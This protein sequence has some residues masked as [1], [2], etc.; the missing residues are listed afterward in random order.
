MRNW[1]RYVR[2]HLPPLPI[3]AERETEIVEELAQQLEAAY[4]A[5]LAHGVSDQE[6]RARALAEVPDWHGL[7]RTLTDIERKAAPSPVIGEPTGSIMADFF[8]DLRYALRMLRRAPGFATLAI[9]TLALG[10]G[11]TTIVYSLVDGILLKPLPIKDPDRVVL[12]R[13]INPAGTERGVA[14]P[15]YEDWRARATSFESLAAWVGGTATLTGLDR[16]RRINGRSVTWDLFRTLG[17]QPII[18]RDFTAD[19]DRPGVERVCLISY[20]FWQ[21]ELGGTADAIGRLLTLNDQR[22]TIVGVLPRDFTV[23]RQEDVFRPIGE[24]LTPG[25]FLLSRGNHSGL[26]AIGR[27]APGATVES[28]RTELATIAA[29]LE[30][31]HPETNSGNGATT[32]PLF[33]VLVSDARPMLRVLMGAV[34]AMLLIACVNLANLLLAR[35]SARSQELAVRW[36][37]PARASRG[38]CSPRACCSRCAAASPARCSPGADS[39]SS[40]RCCRPTSRASTS[41]RLISACSR[42]RRSCRS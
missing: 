41:S 35:S 42:P 5:A 14:W 11:A 24:L 15:N 40:C 36:A 21:R 8:R 17:V 13:E 19:D 2:A 4:D 33:D 34:L 1:R 3:G 6:A 27:L 10:I 12:A 39:T 28:A 37:R 9:T 32:R 38:S 26:A 18:G 25:S 31:Q 22:Y 29:Q 20:G 16:P 7:A 30:Q 23:A